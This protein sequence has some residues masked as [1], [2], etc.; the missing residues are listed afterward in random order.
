[1]DA[2]VKDNT[3]RI[4]T[5][6]SANTPRQD[7][8]N[9]AIGRV[10]GAASPRDAIDNKSWAE[11]IHRLKQNIRID[12]GGKHEFEKMLRKI[13]RF[14]SEAGHPVPDNHDMV[15][16][17]LAQWVWF[18]LLI[19]H[20]NVDGVAKRQMSYLRRGEE[21]FGTYNDKTKTSRR[22]SRAEI[23]EAFASNLRD[24]A[25]HRKFLKEQII[26]IKKQGKP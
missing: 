23:D 13:K 2:F 5:S 10:S 15:T 7:F 22:K 9:P 8:G 11:I 16:M 24:R 25:A 4:L 14:L 18:A 6:I 17:D 3:N 1:V 12:L 21:E 20:S 19:A 26:N